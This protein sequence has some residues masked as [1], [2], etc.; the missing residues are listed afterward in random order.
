V[1]QVPED[2]VARPAPTQPVVDRV[3]AWLGWF[4]VARLMV[5]AVSMVI[6]CV[7]A[8]WLVRSP[9]PPAEAVL[10]RVSSAEIPA[11]T[12]ATPAVMANEPTDLVTTGE[13]LVH[14]AGAVVRPGVYRLPNGERVDDA[15]RA[16]GGPTPDADLDVLNLAA[17]VVDGARVYVP[18]EGEVAPALSAVESGPVVEAPAGPV[19]INR[20]DAGLLDTLP[21][22]GPATAAAIVSE[23]DRNGPFLGV[24]DLERVPGIGP[25]K[26]AGLRE[27]VTA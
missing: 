5:S 26:L 19:D 9:S 27:L 15:V 22:V 10:P 3:R 7:G 17:L 14:V 12:L 13:V 8:F 6:V 20:A 16:A 2:V 21:G 1:E 18:V 4:G 25:A 24:D 23:R 11:S